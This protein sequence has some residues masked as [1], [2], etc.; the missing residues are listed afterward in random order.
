MKKILSSILTFYLLFLGLSTT[1]LAQEVQ[2]GITSVT[3]VHKLVIEQ[4]LASLNDEGQI[5]ISATEKE[6][7]ISKSLFEEYEKAMDSANKFVILGIASFDE[8]Y[9]IIVPS[10][11]EVADIVAENDK[12]NEI[13]TKIAGPDPGLEELNLKSLVE[14][15]RTELEDIYDTALELWPFTNV[16]PYTTTVGFFVG[17]VREGGEWDY[18]V[19]P[20]YSP[21]YKEFEAYTYDGKEVISSE[22]IGNYNYAYVGEFLFSKS[23]LLLGGGAVGAG[24]GQPEDDKDRNTITRGYNDAVE[25]W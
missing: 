5:V 9:Q 23:I 6:L 12:N 20:G 21:W 11:D 15:N 19:Q 4:D 8:D 1:S 3:D 16:D 7:R 17:K 25:Y 14:N 18:K 22:F 13:S 2:P 24:V 10:Q